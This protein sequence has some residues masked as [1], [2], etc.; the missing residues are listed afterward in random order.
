M[1][2][3]AE[4]LDMLQGEGKAYM[5]ALLPN[6]WLMKASLEEQSQNGDLVYAR[7][8]VQALLRCYEKR[9]GHLFEDGDLLMATALHP[10]FTPRPWRAL[11]L[12]RWRRSGTGSPG[13]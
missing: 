6:L 5:G 12:T 8:L 4:C 10:T 1:Q 3:V 11:P 2:P 9:F 7:P 13:S